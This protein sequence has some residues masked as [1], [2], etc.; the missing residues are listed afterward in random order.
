[1]GYAFEIDEPA[2]KR[3]LEGLPHSGIE[4]DVISIC[5]KDSTEITSGDRD[6]LVHAV[7]ST[8]SK[9]IV[10]THGTDTMIETAQYLRASGAATGKVVAFTGA[11]K[12]ERFKDSDA[13]FNLGAAVAATSFLPEG[14][15]FVCMGGNVMDCQKVTRT[16]AGLFVEE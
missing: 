9:R 11:M 12:P 5:R 14:N 6:Q 8:S 10:V 15:V 4:F 16:S 2:A 7:R 3:I 13:H 1:M